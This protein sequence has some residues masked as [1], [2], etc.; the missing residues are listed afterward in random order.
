MKRTFEITLA[1]AT[2]AWAAIAC[3]PAD[4]GS[5]SVGVDDN[6]PDVQINMPANDPGP[7]TEPSTNMPSNPGA[8]GTPS[9]PSQIAGTG[10]PGSGNA[11]PPPT[12]NRPN[13]PGTPPGAPSGERPQG[14]PGG[15]WQGGAPEGADTSIAL[16]KIPAPKYPGATLEETD[17]AIW[18]LKTAENERYGVRLVTSDAPDKIREW[19]STQLTDIRQ[20][21]RFMNG[22]FGEYRVM[23]ALNEGS[24]GRTVI[25]MMVTKGQFGRGPGGGPGGGRPDGPAGQGGSGAPGPGGG[26]PGGPGGS[27]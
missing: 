25:R 24:N 21:D 10:G 3:N 4:T 8:P 26:R 6:A 20:N 1:L 5:V 15:Q 13:P 2:L 23:V 14:R 16:D 27:F 22:A 9:D 18:A 17:D 7:G 11:A 19:Y 12:G